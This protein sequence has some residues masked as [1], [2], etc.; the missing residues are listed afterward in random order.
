MDFYWVLISFYLLLSELTGFYR[1][2]TGYW[3]VCLG[4]SGLKL[5][6]SLGLFPFRWF[7]RVSSI[8]SFQVLVPK[9]GLEGSIFLRPDGDR[10]A[11]SIFTYDPEVSHFIFLLFFTFF[12]L[13]VRPPQEP[14]QSVGAVKLRVFDRVVVRLSLDVR[15]VQ[16]QKLAVHL[17]EP[18]V[19]CNASPDPFCE[20]QSRRNYALSIS[21]FAASPYLVHL[22]VE[23]FNI[24]AS[25]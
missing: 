25:A 11:A 22:F 16:H 19:R 9:F 4:L 17:V 21:A 1:V 8:V 2:L 12:T 6:L 13:A 24:V 14:S 7:T 18:K 20:T 23:R 5:E 10:K 3:W 15:H